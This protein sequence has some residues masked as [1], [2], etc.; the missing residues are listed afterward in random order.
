MTIDRQV[1]ANK[2]FSQ[3]GAWCA[4][5][6]LPNLITQESYIGF[7][8]NL[9]R[10]HT[11]GTLRQKMRH[12]YYA[13]ISGPDV[14]ARDF[15]FENYPDLRTVDQILGEPWW[16]N[17]QRAYA[18]GLVISERRRVIRELDNFFRWCQR[19]DG[20]HPEARLKRLFL[21]AAIS[22]RTR[23][24]RISRLCR[25]LDAVFPGHEDLPRLRKVQTALAAKVWP[26]KRS[27]SRPARRVPEVEA[28]L[29]GQKHR[30]T[31]EPLKPDTID[32]YR[33]ALNLHFDLLNAVGQPFTF[34]RA[35]IDTFAIHVWKKLGV[36]DQRGNVVE[37][38]EGRESGWSYQTALTMCQSI[39]P[40]ID[41]TYLKRRW[42]RFAANFEKKAAGQIKAKERALALRPTSLHD[43]FRRAG[44]LCHRADAE[45]NVQVR[46]GL[47]TTLGA[48][49]I[50][51]FFPLRQGDLRGLRIGVELVRRQGH[52]VLMPG[53]TGKVNVVVD[54]IVLPAEG[55]ELIDMCLLAGA[56]KARLP[57][58]YD[59]RVGTPLVQSRRHK[60][61][62]GRAAFTALFKRW[63]EHTPHILRTLWCDELV[64]R[65]ADRSTI[66]VMLQHRSPI[67]QEAY[68]VI[69]GKIRRI[70][71]I[72]ALHAIG[73][74]VNSG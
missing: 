23:Y 70:R 30:E 56:N 45:T 73:E 29:S 63:T 16:P 3:F 47:L 24:Q 57:E 55:G 26:S 49:G 18:A 6:G 68:Q 59:Q 58:I 43:M 2:T 51:L 46:H 74:Q 34:D 64:A 61:A 48:L 7:E 12:L 69:A 5:E 42:H 52:W 33:R 9:R 60:G 13:G 44:E 67:S 39:A 19:T 22:P 53:T 17:I 20:E 32:R 71:A 27:V 37:R 41:D 11:E 31:G 65:G 1:Q 38:H 40:F 72:E 36:I 10:T 15:L 14:E 8:A 28:L 25:G 54:P 66:G 50:L 35:A 62:Y 4:A 21:D